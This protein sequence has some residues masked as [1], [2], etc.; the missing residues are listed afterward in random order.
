LSKLQLSSTVHALHVHLPYWLVTLLSTV[1]ATLPWIQYS[2]RF[3]L[4]ALLIATTLIAVIVGT[5][6]IAARQ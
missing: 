2:H 1:V 5:I 3:R 4:R 6:V